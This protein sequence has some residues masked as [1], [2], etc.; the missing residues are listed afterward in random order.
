VILTGTGRA[1]CAGADLKA[2]QDQEGAVDPDGA[3]AFVHEVSAVAKR[4]AQLPMPVIAAINGIALAGGLEFL[5]ACDLVLA[6]EGAPIGD[7][8]ANYGLLPGAGGSVRLPRIVGETVAK[9]MMFTGRSVPAEDLMVHGLVNE[10]VP[11]EQL[12][13]RAMLLATELCQRSKLG[14]ATMKR[15]IDDGLSQ[16]LDTALRLEA[17]AHDAHSHSRDFAEGLAAFRERR[18]PRF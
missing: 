6:A 15:L 5:L 1:F 7:A 3:A 13:D 12:Q 18:A 11:A 14:L 2:I 17:H 8:H 9:Y 10:T 4:L 16:P